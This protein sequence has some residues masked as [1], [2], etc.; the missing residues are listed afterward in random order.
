MVH[1]D[2]PQTTFRVFSCGRKGDIISEIQ[3]SDITYYAACE[4]SQPTG[5]T[6]FSST[7]KN[8]TNFVKSL[9]KKGYQMDHVL[10]KQTTGPPQMVYQSS[11]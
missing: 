4:L 7:A 3:S 8:R 10:S 11:L 1:N 2:L 5:K 9:R 6:E